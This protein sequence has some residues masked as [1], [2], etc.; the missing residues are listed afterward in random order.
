MKSAAVSLL[1]AALL[2][3]AQFGRAAEAIRLANH[4]ALSP[5]GQTLV[6]D[7][8]GDIWSVATAGGTARRL[9][10]HPARDR[11]PRFS[12]DGKQLAFISERG[13]SPQVH[14]M[15]AA[16]GTPRQLT[17]HTAGCLLQDW[18]PDG[19]NL[20]I[21]ANRDH[22]WRHAER[23]F[24]ISAEERQAE[25]LLFDDYGQNGC[26]SP[27]GKRLLFTRE[28]PAW[29]RK[30]YRGSQASQIWMYDLESKEFRQ[31][32]AEE[33]GCRWPLWKPDGKGFYYVSARS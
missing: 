12:P 22:F 1:A 31:L 15:F 26:L 14:I 32:L 23:F 13:G 29:W 33:T 8:D 4:P 5:D 25:R 16:G 28:G 18:C 17:Y 19:R 6:F 21:N 20:L 9:T 3:A 24:T 27:D 7:W 30:G 10:N 11:E 2:L